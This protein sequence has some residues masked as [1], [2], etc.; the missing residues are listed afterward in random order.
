MQYIS[1]EEFLKQDEKIRKDF[2]DWWQPEFGDLFLEDYRNEDS[3]INVVGCVP[4]NKKHFEDYNGKIHY[5]TDLTI[6]LL[7]ESQLRNFIEENLDG[8]N[9]YFESYTN[10][11]TKL[12]VEYE[13]N[14]GI[15]DCDVAEYET[16]CDDMLEGY[17][18]IACMIANT[19]IKEE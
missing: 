7:T 14:K 12:I 15:E 1:T 8:C 18:E 17:W 5:K 11:D 4:I 13:Y 16:E 3:E 10:G 6:P 19:K 2:I 9:I